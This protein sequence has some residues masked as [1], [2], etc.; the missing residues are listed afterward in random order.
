MAQADMFELDGHF[1]DLLPDLGFPMNFALRSLW[2]DHIF[3]IWSKLRF[4]L[5]QVGHLGL[6]MA[7]EA[8]R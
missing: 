2:K 8:S 5:D 7:Q 1:C 4:I 3:M 6:C